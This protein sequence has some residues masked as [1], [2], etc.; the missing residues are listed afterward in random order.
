QLAMLTLLAVYPASLSQVELRALL[1]SGR[2]SV[3]GRPLTEW[4][5]ERALNALRQMRLIQFDIGQGRYE[6]HAV[7]RHEMRRSDPDM[8]RAAIA[9]FTGGAPR[10]ETIEEL[11]RLVDAIEVAIE[12]LGDFEQAHQLLTHLDSGRRFLDLGMPH[13][14]VSCVG[15]FVAEDLW[16]DGRTRRE[17]AEQVLGKTSI[18]TLVRTMRDLH[19]SLGNLKEAERWRRIDGGLYLDLSAKSP[20]SPEVREYWL[21]G[22]DFASRMGDPEGFYGVLA[23]SWEHYKELV[24]SKLDGG[25]L[26]DDEDLLLLAMWFATSVGLRQDSGWIALADDVVKQAMRFRSSRII[27]FA[28]RALYHHLDVF[29]EDELQIP[30]GRLPVQRAPFGPTGLTDQVRRLKTALYRM[31]FRQMAFKQRASSHVARLKPDGLFSIVQSG[32]LASDA[33]S[34]DWLTCARALL[35]VAG[36]F[37]QARSRPKAAWARSWAASAFCHADQASDSF[38]LVAQA[39]EFCGEDLDERSRAIYFRGCANLAL[40]QFAAALGDA[41]TVLSIVPFDV[42]PSYTASH[43]ALCWIAARELGDS[44]ATYWKTEYLSFCARVYRID[45]Y[46]ALRVP[47]LLPGEP[48]FQA[49]FPHLD[50]PDELLMA[51]PLPMAS[52]EAIAANRFGDLLDQ[53]RKNVLEPWRN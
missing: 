9:S 19:E 21:L 51:V 15:R 13:I 1:E 17:A 5:G 49:A 45:E 23:N 12:S 2:V 24:R 11:Q 7:V 32:F 10:V 31:A 6:C 33:T 50:L 16:R 41:E 47:K 46:N 38:E 52:L 53:Y 37:E 18:G 36:L 30:G 48:G 35:A 26:A 25:S 39:L 8:A 22:T 40:G 34:A 20:F 4:E 43:L 27:D 42:R 44:R 29:T 3:G 14:G 28:L